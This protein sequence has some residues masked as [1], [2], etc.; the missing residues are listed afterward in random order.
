MQL[1][2]DSTRA[3]V[4]AEA[5]TTQQQLQASDDKIRKFQQ[6]IEYAQQDA[7]AANEQTAL[8]LGGVHVLQ[9]KTVFLEIQLNE[10]T[11]ALEASKKET[12]TAT[13]KS[14]NVEEELAAAHTKMESLEEE[15]GSTRDELTSS[16]S[17]L[18]AAVYE[19]SRLDQELAATRQSLDEANEQA[20]EYVKQAWA[21]Y[22][23]LINGHAAQMVE[24]LQN[25]LDS[26]EGKVEEKMKGF[27]ENI[28]HLVQAIDEKM[29]RVE[30]ENDWFRTE[31]ESARNEI[32]SGNAN[33]PS[34]H[35]R[36]LPSPKK[37]SFSSPD[38]PGSSIL[39]M[40]EN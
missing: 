29:K 3:R 23:P 8:A 7:D 16:K 18:T 11:S 5:I 26:L 2:L 40:M 21:D 4:E 1:E 28:S 14:G 17:D 20:V 34:P 12:K 38:S 19:A 33:I 6:W 30:D 27:S 35:P 15:L 37:K 31:L 32:E 39:D 24:P 22:E 25:G 36:H 13:N 9:Q 10:A